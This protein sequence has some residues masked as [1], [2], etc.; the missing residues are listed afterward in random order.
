MAREAPPYLYPGER[1]VLYDGV[2]KLCNRWANFVMQH[3]VEQL[4]KLATVQSEEGQALLAWA[5]LPL[6]RFDTMVMIDHDRLYVRSSAFLQAARYF[7]WPWQAL[8]Y[9]RRVPVPVR[10][11]LYDK[12]ARNR[13]RWFGRYD[14]CIVPSA[15]HD[16]RFVKARHD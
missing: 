16:R 13:Y 2:C 11:W 3:D 8:K 15:D 1:V 7:P 12:V 14:A 9:L 6:D 10:D 4:I 5:E